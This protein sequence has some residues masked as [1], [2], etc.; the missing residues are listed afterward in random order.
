MWENEHVPYGYEYFIS[1]SLIYQHRIQDEDYEDEPLLWHIGPTSWPIVQFTWQ[2]G[3]TIW[4]LKATWKKLHDQPT[5]WLPWGAFWSSFMGPIAPQGCWAN[6]IPYLGKGWPKLPK[7]RG[8]ILLYLRRLKIVVK[9]LNTR[10]STYWKKASIC[11]SQSYTD[12]KPIV[13]ICFQFFYFFF[14]FFLGFFW[15]PMQSPSVDM[16]QILIMML[17]TSLNLSTL[18]KPWRIIVQ[19]GSSCAEL[20]LKIHYTKPRICMNAECW[21]TTR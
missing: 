15:F 3:P 8:I 5:I 21:R 17:H 14:F 12:W 7:E 19:F 4:L 10:C 20:Q 18:L 1:F 6:S 13:E 11:M 16:L 2:I 9:D